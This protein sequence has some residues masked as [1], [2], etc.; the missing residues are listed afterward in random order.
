LRSENI[1]SNVL[2]ENMDD[3]L[4]VKGE[5]DGIYTRKYAR[6]ISNYFVEHSNVIG[7]FAFSAGALFS[8][9]S[10]NDFDFNIYPG[11]DV[12][13]KFLNNYKIYATINKS[14]RLPTFT[15]LFYSGP[16]NIGNPD[17]KPEQ[18]W[19]YELGVK[20]NGRILKTD[21]SFFIRD[22]KNIIEWVKSDS[23]NASSKWE[24]QNL[25][26]VKTI[27]F[28][29]SNRIT[30]NRY[31]IN[32][33]SIN[34]TYI[35]QDASA[36]GYQTKYSLNYLK[37]NVIIGLNQK[38]REDLSLN[39]SARYQDRA[40]NYLKYNY[41]LNTYDGEKEFAPF[42][43]LDIKVSY[44]LKAITFYAEAT[45]VF[46]KEYIDIANIEMP[47]RWFKAGLHVLISY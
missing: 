25:T 1:W 11:F 21:I 44:Q 14:L 15:D 45:N 42:W 6:T 28:E 31:T 18:A 47:G 36:D 12:S 2:G 19:S 30:I 32:N 22:S 24:T 8:W 34:Y 29:T 27:G 40:G 37:H 46:N 33:I 38:I 43:L 3:T 17:L 41:D 39:W 13:Y 10:E 26:Q 16:S 4:K 20:Y 23:A 5:L 9:V 35:N 7:N